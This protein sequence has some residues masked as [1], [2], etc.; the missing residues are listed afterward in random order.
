MHFFSHL[1]PLLL[2]VL[3]AD[4]LPS[5]V[6]WCGTSPCATSVKEMGASTANPSINNTTIH[7]PVSNH[8]PPRAPAQWWC[9]THPCS[10]G[11]KEMEGSRL[12]NP[13]M[14][15][16]TINDQVS[17]NGTP[18]QWWCGTHPCPRMVAVEKRQINNTATDIKA[19]NNTESQSS[20]PKGA[21]WSWWCRTHVC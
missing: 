14:N 6:G 21:W 20:R 16:T 12:T 17:G 19:I 4:G 13:S 5:R 3:S 11:V 7:T 15:D 1:P 9:G 8:G 2:L 10:A 18:R